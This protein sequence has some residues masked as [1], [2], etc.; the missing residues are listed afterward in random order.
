M[1]LSC[2]PLAFFQLLVIA[3]L[4][5][6]ASCKKNIDT[7]NDPIVPPG[8][9]LPIPAASPVNGAVSGLVVNE[10]NLPVSGAEVT[11]GTETTTT[12]ARG[13][14]SFNNITLD[15]YTST[16]TV[17][18]TGYHKGIRSFSAS[19]DRNYVSI[20]LIPKTLSGTISSS[21]ADQVDLANGTQLSFQANSIKVKSSGATYNGTV[22][23]YASYIDPT[24]ADISTRLPGSFVGQD[25]GNVYALQSAGMIAVELESPTGEA[26]QLVT[27]KPVTIQMPIPASLLDKAPA[28]IDTWS[29]NDQGIW[30]KEGTATRNGNNY[31]MQASHFSF[32]NLDVPANAVYLT[33]HVQ[34]QN[35][36]PVA[37]ALV[38]LSVPN[39]NTW[40]ATTYGM[41][42]GQGNVSGFVPAGLALQMNVTPNPI[43]CSTPVATQTIGPFSSNTNLTVTVNISN[44]QSLTITGTAIDCAGNP[45]ANGIALI[46]AGSNNFIS[47]PVVNGAYTATLS[48]CN[49]ISSVT[50]SITDS[51]VAGNS[52]A[53]SVTGNSVT[54][55][56]ISVCGGI[57]NAVFTFGGSG[58]SCQL[59]TPP[60]PLTAGVP[61]NASNSFLISVDVSSIGTYAINTNLEN[62]ISFSANGTFSSLGTQSIILTGTGTPINPGSFVYTLQ[63]LGV[64]G[65]S[66]PVVVNSPSTVAQFNLADPITC[67]SPAVSG[68]Y[69]AG[70]PLDSNTH[71][72]ALTV[73]VLSAGSYT[74]SSPTLNGVTF[75]ASGFF[76]LS[77]PQTIIVQA[78]GT[79]VN[80]GGFGYVLNSN[81]GTTSC[82]VVIN[83]NSASTSVFSYQVSGNECAGATVAGSYSS[84]I[85]LIGQNTVALQVNVTSTGTYNISTNVTNGFGF[86]GAGTFTTTGIQ[87]IL[88]TAQ[89]TPVTQGT[90]TFSTAS[91]SSNG[92]IFT[93]PVN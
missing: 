74:I 27:D 21:A 68:N 1:K 8:D 67:S 54:V 42:D 44:N 47:A 90:F 85:P 3:C 56:V 39:N 7:G 86:S 48:H 29:L 24:A 33:L 78:S 43:N 57:P 23:I 73:N 26:L 65:C 79:P 4:L 89:G 41:T 11:L 46:Y 16:I 20:K 36:N 81:T 75:S 83:V 61:L 18:A 32:W 13:L 14:F 31:Q 50:V 10:N 63:S 2:K 91:P 72:I 88:L 12:D 30:K 66:L 45:L 87:T 9:V 19:N 55:P 51:T 92:C 37:N 52:G 17:K 80:A 34:D 5:L 62:G 25:A 84:G 60:L 71:Y 64:T 15:K 93:V 53:V 6:F 69:I 77:G 70:V 58:L 28:T 38:Q 49:P 35:G 22:N 82:T 40:W 76:A 59:N